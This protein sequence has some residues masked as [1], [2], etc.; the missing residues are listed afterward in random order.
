M[1]IGEVGTTVPIVS[2]VGRTMAVMVGEMRASEP[3][4]QRSRIFI[5]SEYCNKFVNLVLR[6][7]S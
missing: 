1:C 2:G 7:S 6:A 4:R 3:V 5:L